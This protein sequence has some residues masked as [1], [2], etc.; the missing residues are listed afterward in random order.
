LY[1]CQ[2]RQFRE[3]RLK[4]FPVLL[5]LAKIQKMATDR[6]KVIDGEEI[7]D[8]ILFVKAN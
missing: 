3:K 8:I 7:C 4:I 5:F 6:G 2:Y 1:K